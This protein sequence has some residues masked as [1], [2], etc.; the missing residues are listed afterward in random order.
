MRCYRIKDAS[1]STAAPVSRSY[2]RE[3]IGVSPLPE[4]KKIL[5][6]DDDPDIRAIA[7]LSLANIGGFEVAQCSSGN[8]ALAIAA[9]FKPQLLLLDV[10][11]PGISGEDLWQELSKDP[12]LAET[13]VIFMTAKVERQ[14]VDHLISI[15]ALAVVQKPFDAMELPN[16]IR[17]SWEMRG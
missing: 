10:M 16:E 1:Q 2:P 6:V 3:T 9:S 5:H 13:P 11:M 8:E 12:D 17:K 14:F 4:L 7:H 15:G